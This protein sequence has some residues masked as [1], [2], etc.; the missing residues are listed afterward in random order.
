MHL[1]EEFFT[2]VGP[3][4]ILLVLIV[5]MWHSHILGG[6]GGGGGVGL[7]FF[8]FGKTW[9]FFFKGGGGGG[10]GAVDLFNY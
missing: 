4:G 9:V 3:V 2:V 8:F 7:F 6:G 5:E 1:I 10:R